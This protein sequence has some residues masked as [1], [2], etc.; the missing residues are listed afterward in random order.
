MVPEI[1][2][3]TAFSPNALGMILSRPR[4]SRNSRSSRFVVRSARRWVIGKHR[5]ACRPRSRPQSR[6]RRSAVPAHSRR[7]HRHAARGRWPATGLGSRARTRSLKSGHAGSGTLTTRL[8]SSSDRSGSRCGSRRRPRRRARSNPGPMR[9]RTRLARPH[10]RSARGQPQQ[11]RALIAAA[12]R[13]SISAGSAPMLAVSSP[14][15]VPGCVFHFHAAPQPISSN[16]RPS[17]AWLQAHASIAHSES[18][19]GPRAGRAHR[20]RG[21]GKSGRQSHRT[22]GG[23]G[24]SRSGFLGTASA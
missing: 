13:P 6:P 19:V 3:R 17:S 5:W 14:W 8:R 18:I 2:L 16:P 7:P 22:G 4:S 15:G 23:G 21:D 1:S 24:G 10:P 9:P 12:S 20:L 11:S